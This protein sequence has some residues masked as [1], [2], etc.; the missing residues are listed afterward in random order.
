MVANFVLNKKKKK[1]K[2]MIKAIPLNLD[3]SPT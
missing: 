2:E 3:S 1:K